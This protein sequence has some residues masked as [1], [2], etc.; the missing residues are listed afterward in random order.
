MMNWEQTVKHARNRE[1]FSDL[2]Y[3]SYLSDDLEDNLR[4]YRTSKEYSEIKKLITKYGAN[5]E[6]V[7]DVGSGNGISAVSFALDGFDVT[8]IEPDKSDS[9]GSGAIKILKKKLSLNNLQVVDSI[10]ETMDIENKKFDM[11]FVR[12]ALHHAENLDKF[13]QNTAKYLKNGGVFIAVRE[14][15]VFDKKDKELFLR[16]HPLN[17]FYSGENAYTE[18]EY[19]T[20]FKKA[21]LDV[22]SIFRFFDSVI[23]YFPM[24][25]E[26]IKLIESR[27]VC[28]KTLKRLAK[29]LLKREYIVD[30]RDFPG[31]MYSFVAVKK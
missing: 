12:Q 31:R 2:I 19:L 23:N 29:C 11:I 25:S 27:G 16:T 4:R 6:T 21:G 7:L 5:T 18:D 15:V 3:Y 9:V 30:E 1:E 24:S 26:R 10:A 8:A 22:V 20:A 13:V 28:I 14:H 17:S